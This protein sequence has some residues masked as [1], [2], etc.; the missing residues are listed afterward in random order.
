MEFLKN[1]GSPR[2]SSSLF[3]TCSAD[4]EGERD[5]AFKTSGVSEA[6]AAC[7]DAAYSAKSCRVTLAI[8][9]PLALG[10]SLASD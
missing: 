2:E 6:A 1:L 3:F 4:D 5:V 9:G 7:G 8:Y 10:T